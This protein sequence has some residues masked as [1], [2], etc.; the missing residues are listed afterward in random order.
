MVIDKYFIYYKQPRQYI[1]WG[2]N[3]V[4]V[5][6]M[7][8]T[9]KKG[10][11][12]IKTFQS[13]SLTDISPEDFKSAVM[14]LPRID[15]GLILNSTPFIFNIFD[16]DKIPFQENLKKDLVE[17][18]L[19]KVFPENL[20]EYEH[21]FPVMT[22]TRV[23]SILIKKN[24][25]EKIETLFEENN[26]PLIGVANSTVESINSMSGM[27]KSCPDFFI[28]IDKSLTL[29]VFMEKGVP[30]YVRKFRAGQAEDLT[31]E[32]IKT[33]N[34]VKNSY[35]KIPRSCLI[36]ADRSHTELDFQMVENQLANVQV[37]SL[38]VSDKE[39]ILFTGK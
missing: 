2:E 8:G 19:K 5:Y 17:W 3:Y 22:R 14:E 18:R 37:G 26:I 24:L 13:P 6:G 1:Y 38:G 25:K 27:K 12:K 9:E 30:Y 16:F 11:K 20:G 23:L 36:V 33:I 21:Q 4:D 34:F 29:L 39:K 10:M 28:E 31:A 15:T 32:T 7:P 35:A